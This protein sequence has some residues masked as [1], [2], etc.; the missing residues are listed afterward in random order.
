HPNIVTV[1]DIGQDDDRFYI[2]ME[3]VEGLTLKEIIRTQAAPSAGGLPIDRA[4]HLVIQICAGIGYAHRA[5][6]VHCD[7]KPQNIIVTGDDRVKVADFGI[8]RALSSSSVYE[9]SVVWGTPQYLSPEQASGQPLTAASDVYS[10]GVI[11][12]E[13][14]TGRL[15]FDDSEPSAL[16]MKHLGETPPLV[17]RF[18]RAVPA[19]LEQVVAKVLS[20]EPAGRYRTA[21]QLGRVLSTYRAGSDTS[22]RS[23]PLDEQTRVSSRG[24]SAATRQ[25]NRADPTFLSPTISATDRPPT[26]VI[27]PGDLRIPAPPDVEETDWLAVVLGLLALVAVLGLIPLWYAIYLRFAG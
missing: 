6:F 2:V 18:N 15:P 26:P 27:P 13:L 23:L 8:A 22:T 9:E 12:F 1:H 3:F 10:I 4:L 11:L 19:Q 21:D 25:T 17:S 5:N 16:L 20:K 14:L 24:P 7:V